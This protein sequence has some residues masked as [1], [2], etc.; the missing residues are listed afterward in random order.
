MVQAGGSGLL[1]F[2]V[3][4]A[5]LFGLY[6][7]AEYLQTRVVPP[8]PLGPVLMLATVLV[9]WPVGRWLS[10]GG[11]DAY[12][13]DRRI[14]SL[15]WLGAWFVLA[16]MAKLGALAVGLGLGAVTLDAST[17]RPALAGIAGALSIAALTTFIPS[18]AEDMITRGLPLRIPAIAGSAPVYLA[19]TAM[20]YTANHIWRLGWGPTEQ[21]RLFCLGLA[22]AAGAWR[23]KSLWGAVAL[24]WG[25]NFAGATGDLLVPVTLANDDANRLI[26]A[27]MHVVLMV[28]ML[29]LPGSDRGKHHVNQR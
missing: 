2:G 18:V 19:F 12:G 21:L 15:R 16:I 22:Y 23:A 6:Q 7:T 24:H 8:S 5:I 29:L 9:A 25:W 28:T 3:A 20:L 14:D 17:A 1:R 10:G 11:Y 27:G 26:S 4:F 13:L